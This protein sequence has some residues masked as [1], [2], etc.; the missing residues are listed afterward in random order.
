MTPGIWTYIHVM[1]WGRKHISIESYVSGLKVRL[2]RKSFMIYRPI[3]ND[4]W[5]EDMWW[6]ILVA[7]SMCVI[8]IRLQLQGKLPIVGRIGE[9]GTYKWHRF[10]GSRQHVGHQQRK[11]RL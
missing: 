9:S 10:G 7:T 8:N 11:H 4:V 2:V 6:V 3:E 5:N 1:K